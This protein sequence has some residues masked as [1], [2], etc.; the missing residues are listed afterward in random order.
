MV[1]GLEPTRRAI[2]LPLMMVL[3]LLPL[4]SGTKKLSG[5]GLS[6]FYSHRARS[7][8]GGRSILTT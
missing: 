2:S 8:Q 7:P 4:S 5:F 1:L 6:L 3:R